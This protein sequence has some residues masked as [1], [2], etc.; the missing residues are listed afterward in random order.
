VMSNRVKLKL[1][2][3]E[4]CDSIKAPVPWWDDRLA[5]NLDQ[6][7][8][9][10]RFQ[11]DRD[12]S[13]CEFP[14]CRY[15]AADPDE[16]ADLLV[17]DGLDD[18]TVQIEF[19]HNGLFDRHE[20]LHGMAARFRT[21]EQNEWLNIPSDRLAKLFTKSGRGLRPDVQQW[22]NEVLNPMSRPWRLRRYSSSKSMQRARRSVDQ[23][24]EFWSDA[25]LIAFRLQWP[26]LER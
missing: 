15:R 24:C 11:A 26:E 4:P 8:T 25:D 19:D 20:S 17:R 2:H 6:M 3:V 18:G 1:G 22:W 9:S 10:Y 7:V 5:F 13:T 12:C 21:R 14:D 16:L 23:F